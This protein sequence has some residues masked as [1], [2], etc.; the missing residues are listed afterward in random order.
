VTRIVFIHWGRPVG[1]GGGAMVLRMMTWCL[2]V[3]GIMAMMPG[4]ASSADANLSAKQ[5][6]EKGTEFASNKLYIDAIEYFTLA[7]KKN[8]GE[9]PIGDVAMIFNSRGL[10]HLIRNNDDK[11]MGDFSNAIELDDKNQEFFLNR[12]TLFL[13]QKQYDRARNDFSAAIAL[14]PRNAAAYAGRARAS[15]E[16]GDHDKALADLAKLLELEPRNFQAL[17]S[18][19]LSCKA[20]QQNDLALEAFDKVLKIEPTHAA[21]SYQKAGIYART[22]KID[23]A[24]TWLEIAVGDGFRDWAALK[25]NPDF[26]A[27]R[28]NSCYQKVIVGK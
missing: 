12:G 18:I 9:I 26:D 3:T 1:K 25:S 17:Y 23:A 28:R 2:I 5:L 15:Q 21:A 11:A 4:G 27:F 13:K 10:V 14:N 8:K 6:W 16:S 7:I 20:K 24:C 22:K 19:G